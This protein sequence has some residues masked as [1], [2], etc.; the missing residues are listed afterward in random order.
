MDDLKG[1]ASVSARCW[2][3][4]DAGKVSSRA[5]HHQPLAVASSYQPR[6]NCHCQADSYSSPM[7]TSGLFATPSLLQRAEF[8]PLCPW[9]F[10]STAMLHNLEKQCHVSFCVVSLA[11]PQTRNSPTLPG[12]GLN[13]N[14]GTR[15]EVHLKEKKN[16][17]LLFCVL[18]GL[19]SSY[20]SYILG[21]RSQKQ[22]QSQRAKCIHEEFS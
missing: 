20:P 9:L 14:R 5:W 4:T 11:A 15:L 6:P 13:C 21:C 8:R 12:A 1:L 3:S 10:C 22:S 18:G 7:N 2:G 16:A 17:S 19:Q